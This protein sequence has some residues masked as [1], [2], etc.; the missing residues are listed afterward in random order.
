M[1]VQG[2]LSFL[3]DLQISP[4]DIVTLVIAYE[5]QASELGEFTKD[6]FLNLEKFGLDSIERIRTYIPK[7][8]EELNDDNQFKRIYRF[9][10]DFYKEERDRRNIDVGSA[11]H[12]W[13]VLLEDQAQTASF[14][15]FV[16]NHQTQYKTINIDQWTNVLEFFRTVKANFSNYDADAAW[17]VL[18]DMYVEWAQETNRN[19]SAEQ[20]E[21]SKCE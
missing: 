19:K 11:V 14:T 8:R 4:D 1:S 6:Q 5:L 12:A 7:F 18:L 15:D 13:R 17:P 16:E 2:I 10:F 3:K 9:A 20:S 21:V